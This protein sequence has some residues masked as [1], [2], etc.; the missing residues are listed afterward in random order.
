MTM[1]KT[2][3][4]I[5]ITCGR[6]GNFSTAREQKTPAKNNFVDWLRNAQRLD[7]NTYPA[8]L[9]P[10]G[11]R[12]CWRMCCSG[13]NN[14]F[15]AGSQLCF[16]CRASV[17]S[18]PCRGLGWAVLGWGCTNKRHDVAPSN[19]RAMSWW[20][21]VNTIVTRDQRRSSS[22]FKMATVE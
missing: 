2:Q 15:L 20:L 7:F 18:L 6:E 12:V 13:R 19:S 21:S 9:P 11:S 1:I 5:F 10:P 14:Y 4:K 8:I 3:V 17:N 16:M 22:L